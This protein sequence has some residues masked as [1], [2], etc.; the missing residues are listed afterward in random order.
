[1]AVF[2][3]EQVA[4]VGDM[5]HELKKAGAMLSDSRLVRAAVS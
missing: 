2:G 3:S 1:M 4:E 5:R